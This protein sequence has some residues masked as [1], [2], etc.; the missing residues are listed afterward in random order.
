[1]LLWRLILVLTLIEVETGSFVVR[2]VEVG[3]R[4]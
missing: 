3:V 1:M 4:S 2:L